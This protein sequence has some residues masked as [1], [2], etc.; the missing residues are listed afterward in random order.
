MK[1]TVV[2]LLV[3]FISLCSTATI[4]SAGMSDDAATAI[5]AGIEAFLINMADMMFSTEF[6]GYANE[7]GYGPIGYIYNIA[8][9]TYNPFSFVITDD[10]IDYSKSVFK[11]SYPILLLGAAIATLVLH[12]RS[13]VLSKLEQLTG[14]KVGRGA[15]ILSQKALGGVAVAVFTYIFIFFVLELNNILTKSVLISII[16]V[17]S[18][19][20]DNVLLYLMMG[21]GYILLGFFFT[22]RT[23]V[24]FLFCGF[25]YLV[26][27][28]LLIDFTHETCMKIC[29]YFVQCVF[30]QFIMVI[31][32]SACIMI[33]KAIVP[34]VNV[35][36]QTN[37]YLVMI[38]GGVYLAIKLML[39]T[40]VIRFVG[41]SAAKL[42]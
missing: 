34:A 21:F 1:K 22:I 14:V 38:L 17:I 20:P 33:I 39:G 30:F 5:S 10:L 28:G 35:P 40:K 16:D 25:A 18:P 31:Y 12:Y 29:A 4:A 7:A 32:F 15:N 3:L 19:T 23:L 36:G 42:V 11:A 8:S 9:Y 41:N 13:D 24:I 6:G 37:M 2:V 26:G 27:L